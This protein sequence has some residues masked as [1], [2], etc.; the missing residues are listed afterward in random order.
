MH[1]L[2]T[3]QNVKFWGIKQESLTSVPHQKS[4]IRHSVFGRKNKN[5]MGQCI[6]YV[7]ISPKSM[8]QLVGNFC[9]LPTLSVV[10][11]RN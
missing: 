10:H 4:N 2:N 5:T 6:G 3:Y 11:P 9:I 1:H 8:I 7:L